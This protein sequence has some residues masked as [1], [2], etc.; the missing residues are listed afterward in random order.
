MNG[1]KR[2]KSYQ[3]NSLPV[4]QKCDSILATSWVNEKF[5]VI[6]TL[7]DSVC[8]IFR[9]YKQQERIS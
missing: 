8:G 3:K 6:D 1:Q 4:C 5:I 2:T 9:L 7:N